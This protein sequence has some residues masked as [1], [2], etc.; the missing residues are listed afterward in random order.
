MKIQFIGCPCSGKT[1]TAAQVFARLKESGMTCEFIPEQARLYIAKARLS[2][3][4]SPRDSLILTDEDQLLIMKQQNA[5]EQLMQRACGDDVL[6]ITDS[7]PL[8]SILYMTDA[9]RQKEEVSACVTQAVQQV[10]L[11]FYSPP[12]MIGSPFDPN[13]VHTMQESLKINDS[14][15]EILQ[16]YAVGVLEKT[17][18]LPKE[19]GNRADIVFN[20]ILKKLL[21]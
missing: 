20:V 4:T 11:I 13:R 1:T 8:N 16:K 7:S 5:A 10:D 21:S 19:P 18:F 3:R 17:I 14:I 6:I 9:F 12:V 15:P 2:S